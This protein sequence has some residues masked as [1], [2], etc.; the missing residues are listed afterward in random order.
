[1]KTIYSIITGVIFVGLSSTASAYLSYYQDFDGMGTIGT[2]APSG[3]SYWYIEGSGSSLVVPT[4]SEMAGAQQPGDP[5]L[6]V[7]NQTSP[8]TTLFLQAANMGATASDANRLLGTSPTSVRGD[9]LQLALQNNSGAAITSVQIAYDMKAM[10]NG[11][12][13]GTD[14]H[15]EL[16]GYRFY[17]LDGSTWTLF[18]GLDLSNDTLNSVGHAS[19]EIT[20]TTPVANGGT[21]QFRWFDD[22]GAQFSPDFMVAIDNVSILVPEPSTLSLVG[23]GALALVAR[24]RKV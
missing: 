23:L 12:P 15:E 9:I 13:T 8:S 11:T 5:T 2:S 14:T 3:W 1:M 18:S 24:R 7:W 21:L 10:A 20:Y 16:P 22:N 17:F 4:S 6:A 19:A